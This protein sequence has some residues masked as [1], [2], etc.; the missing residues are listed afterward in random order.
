MATI[1]HTRNLNPADLSRNHSDWV[2]NGLDC[3][4]TKAIQAIQQPKLN[5][6]NTA[7]T[8]RFEK[9]L[10]GPVLTMSG[11]GI[12]VDTDSRARWI[13]RLEGRLYRITGYGRDDKDRPVL[14]NPDA[15]LQREC[16]KQAGCTVNPNSPLQLKDIFYDK[17]KIPP[18]YKMEKGQK[19]VSTDREALEKIKIFYPRGVKLAQAILLVRDIEKKLN[20]L[21]APLTA[22]GRFRCRYNIAGTETGR[23]SSAANNFDEGGNSQNIT[24]ELRRVFIP[25]DGLEMFYSDLKGAESVA[26]GYISEDEAYIEACN[27]GDIHTAV[28][29]L[30]WPDLG[31]TGDLKTDRRIAEQPYYRQHSF[32]DM[33]KRLGHGTNYLGTPPTMAKNL[34]IQQWVAYLFQAM[35][36]GGTVFTNDLY[37]WGQSK[38]IDRDDVTV[39]GKGA[40]QIAI[41][42]GAFPKIKQW[43]LDT[44]KQLQT[45]GFIVTPMGRRRQF[46]GRTWDDAT[47]REAV[48]YVPQS[49]V[50]EILNLGMFK[51]WRD[52]DAVHGGPL[53]LLGQIHDAILG[54]SPLGMRSE[55]AGLVKEKMKVEVPIK[56][57]IMC[58]QADI[59]FGPNWKAAS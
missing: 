14:L 30:V 41:F 16:I 21:L 39:E 7:L 24:K 51:V 9:L 52:L 42:R 57:R 33:A 13:K 17:L 5:P 6:E 55:I 8:Y 50:A 36:L 3:V 43:H 10:L 18:Q 53:D 27:S 37:R 20:V 29:R 34:K 1:Y 54:Q 23:F 2:Y 32:R 58:L 35:Y 56:G 26:V 25:D 49:L 48:A 4:Y 22:D 12:K 44:A 46:F 31:W 45:E 59:K 28:A 40:H 19:K 38:M 11:R 15:L 47:L